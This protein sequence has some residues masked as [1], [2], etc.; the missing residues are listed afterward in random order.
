MYHNIGDKSGFNTILF[1][2]FK[3]QIEF[4]KSKYSI[5]SLSEYVKSL[6][7]HGYNS[8]K[9]ITITFDDA[10]KSYLN[11]VIPFLQKEEI[12]STVFVPVS[13][14]GKFNIW[15]D[16]REKIELMTWEEL[17]GISRNPF[18]EIGSHG[19]SHSKI[20]KLSNN[21][22]FREIKDSKDILEE[23]LFV[24][25]NHFNFPYGQLN[26]LNPFSIKVLGELDYI[27]ACSA[28]YNNRN[29]LKEYFL[30]KQNRS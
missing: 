15:D 14:V 5:L 9:I 23:N 4:V 1:D 8:N 30:V 28:R 12:S 16:G 29:S 10:Y 2:N 13:H 24:K 6:K 11:K 25:I 20:S 17:K 19:M 27:S 3:K 26:D 22:I 18:V 21:A 7:K